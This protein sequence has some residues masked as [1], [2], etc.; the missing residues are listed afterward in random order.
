M[1][2][3]SDGYGVARERG[4]DGKADSSWAQRQLPSGKAREVQIK[5][6]RGDD[7][8][9]GY[10]CSNVTALDITNSQISALL[11]LIAISDGYGV[12]RERGGDGKADSSWAQRQLP[13]RKSA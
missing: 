12:A 6:D 1:I 8:D 13:R 5:A 2:A 10:A 3:I 11:L 7:L 9:S 4:G